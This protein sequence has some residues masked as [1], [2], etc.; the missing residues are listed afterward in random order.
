M[1]QVPSRLPLKSRRWVT[2]YVTVTVDVTVTVTV[3]VTV[4]VTVD[5]TVTVT[6]DVT[7]I[8]KCW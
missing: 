4:T 5:V 7:E 6:V 3:D 8:W 2:V 1:T